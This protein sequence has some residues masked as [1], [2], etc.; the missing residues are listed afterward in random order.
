MNAELVPGSALTR[1]ECAIGDLTLERVDV[2]V[3]AANTTLRGPGGVGGVDGAI[4]RAA[5]PGLLEECARLHPK[6][7]ATGDA[8]ITSGHGLAAKWVIHSVG[9]VYRDGRSGEAQQLAGAHLR[10]LELADERGLA[11]LSF[12]AI[13]CGAY[14]Y[15]WPGAAEVAL[16]AVAS[17]LAERPRIER[18]RFVLSSPEIHR[19][20][21]ET[22]ARLA[23]S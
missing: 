4:H 19:V 3:N 2:I 18:V 13:S 22:L 12:P 7:C 16:S 11:T 20:F 6:G 15:P 23:R 21:A 14:G 8:R 17:E 9:P 1:I 10:A 5:G